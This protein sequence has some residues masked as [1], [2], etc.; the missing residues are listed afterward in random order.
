MNEGLG[1]GTDY[2]ALLR[3]LGHDPFGTIVSASADPA[4]P[5]AAGTTQPVVAH[6]TTVCAIR[7]ADGVVMAGDRRATAG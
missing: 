3:S 5:A 1:G 2:V 4:R 6:G 7:Y